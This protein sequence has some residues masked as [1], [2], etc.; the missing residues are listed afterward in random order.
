M[1]V[2]PEPPAKRSPFRRTIVVAVA[3]AAVMAALMVWSP[4]AS[5]Q[6]PG[7]E[8]GVG[9]AYAQG[10]RVDPRL[11]RLSFGITYGMALAGHQNTVAVGEARSVDLGVIGTT[12]AAEGCDGG[13]PTLPKEDQPQPLVV[14]STEEGSEKGKAESENGVQKRAKASDD[15]L[16]NAVAVTAASGDPAV[17]EIGSTVSE[18]TSGIVDGKRQARAVTEVSD[19]TFAGGLIVL[20]GLRWDAVWQSAPAE[21]A[22][23][24]FTIEGITAGPQGL[25]PPRELAD[26]AAGLAQANAVLEPLGFKIEPPTVRKESGIAFVDPMRIAVVP[27]TQRE[28]LLGPIFN[29]AQPYRERVYDALIEADCGTASFLTVG[30]IAIGSVTG[31]GSLGIEV[32]GVTASSD[33]LR[34][35]SFLGSL[36]P[37]SPALPP[38]AEGPTGSLGDGAP[39][40]DGVLGG[41]DPSSPPTADGGEQTSEEDG[42]EEERAVADVQLASGSRG[43][44][45]VWVGLGGLALLAA[46]AEGDRRKM[47]RAQRSVPMEVMA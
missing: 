31:A 22:E 12:L 44:P 25:K 21:V 37:F 8:P 11:G 9:N 27:S 47:R 43:G 3:W 30:D 32:G 33:D 23:G 38:V 1:P 24:S 26:G 16:A 35:T 5:G 6:E 20:E 39:S 42:A 34:R 15:P 28:A 45:M 17:I 29:A 2:T 7:V 46:L 19:I 18:T 14:R 36:T 13:D 10:Y 4:S 40:T 41:S